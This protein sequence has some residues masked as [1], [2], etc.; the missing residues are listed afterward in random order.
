[1]STSARSLG[2]HLLLQTGEGSAGNGRPAA[3]LSTRMRAI[4]GELLLF[5]YLQALDLLTTLVGLRAGAAEA[6]PFIRTLM[7]VGPTFGVFASKLISLALGGICLCTKR[8]HLIRWINYWFAAL[9]L[10]NLLVILG[11]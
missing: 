1:M 10:W 3:E 11:R 5:L 2:S 7:H 8:R 4:T 9:I 6:S